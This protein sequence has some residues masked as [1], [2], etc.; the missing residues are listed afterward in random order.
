MN[1]QEMKDAWIKQIMKKADI[2]RA[3]AEAIFSKYYKDNEIVLF[4]SY[5]NEE[6]SL[7]THEYLNKTKE[8]IIHENGT[9]T[10]KK[11][12]YKHP[13]PIVVNNFRRKRKA[14]KALMN[15]SEVKKDSLGKAKYKRLQLA[16]KIA[17]N[18]I[19]GMM[20][21]QK[22]PFTNIDIADT[23]TTTCRV[24]TATA[25]VTIETIGGFYKSSNIHVNLSLIEHTINNIDTIYGKY[26]FYI[27]RV[28]E[29]RSFRNIDHKIEFISEQ[30]SASKENQEFIRTILN[31]NRDPRILNLL[32]IKNNM[33]LFLEV[34]S[35]EIRTISLIA[36]N[37]GKDDIIMKLNKSSKYY[38]IMNTVNDL[39]KDL[40]LGYY[41]YTGDTINGKEYPTTVELM[42]G[43][44]RH[45][46]SLFD[47]DSVV[48]SLKHRQFYDDIAVR[49]LKS[50]GVDADSLK[51]LEAFR[52]H[53]DIVLSV[54]TRTCIMTVLVDYCLNKGVDAEDVKI[55]DFEIEKILLSGQTTESKK[56]YLNR[57]IMHEYIYLDEADMSL[58]GV[59]AI[60]GNKNKDIRE[61][62]IDLFSMIMPKNEKDFNHAEIISKAERYK[63]DLI[64]EIKTNDFICNKSTVVK[65]GKNLE[66]SD[67][68]QLTDFKAK[69]IIV[70]NFM[71]GTTPQ[72]YGIDFIETPASFRSV[73]II[74]NEGI[75]ETFTDIEKE[76]LKLAGKYIKYTKI[77]KSFVTAFT[78]A[79]S[80]TAADLKKLG[81][82]LLVGNIMGIIAK[83][84][85]AYHKVLG[86]HP[87]RYVMVYELKIKDMISAIC[88]YNEYINFIKKEF[89]L[90]LLEEKD[91]L[92]SIYDIDRIALPLDIISLPDFITRNDFGIIDTSSVYLLDTLLSQALRTTGITCI[93]TDNTVTVFTNILNTYPSRKEQMEE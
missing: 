49:E 84:L 11:E 56:S 68:T 8:L 29:L 39:S 38:D 20:V 64:K 63:E 32:L 52:V 27:D 83:P 42:K 30:I 35:N 31:N 87:M 78:K 48:T 75:Y 28:E 5:T 66:T 57:E 65:Y 16:V 15:E 70:W 60:K 6:F 7:K 74:M 89:G 69:A 33:K 34:I 90:Y 79:G 71:E 36:G 41:Y 82:D 47:T 45:S 13:L 23:I 12:V 44:Q 14:Y 53:S 17:I 25:G 91:I 18:S 55:V 93:R 2:D 40:L 19:Y 61:K 24:L 86:D 76:K 80:T 58:T 85:E 67:Y 62:V 92:D 22:S 3:F 4:N 77:Y 51:D 88:K 50:V 21:Y 9:S 10:Y 46:V 72:G 54:I 73:D 43:M 59:Q 37:F 1:Y 81:G 26:K